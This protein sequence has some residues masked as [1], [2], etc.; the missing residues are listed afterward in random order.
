MNLVAEFPVSGKSRG[1]KY[2]IHSRNG[3]PIPGK[4]PGKIDTLVFRF[5]EKS[6]ENRHLGFPVSEKNRHLGFPV[7]GFSGMCMCRIFARQP[8]TKSPR[9]PPPPPASCSAG[10][11]TAPART[12][13]LSSVHPWPHNRTDGHNPLL[14]FSVLQAITVRMKSSSSP[15]TYEVTVSNVGSIHTG[16][17][18]VEAR[19][20]YG[21][22]KQMSLDNY[23][24]WAGESVTLW[25]DGEPY[26][27]FTG[28]LENG[29]YED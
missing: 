19:K 1:N 8:E 7:S 24:R 5:Q 12:G 25:R 6:G 9:K 13:T 18:P 17:N 2:G 16:T 10:G 27:V 3:F 14:R 11:P 26:L 21:E 28:S 15:H 22:A 20:H 29:T 23:G 4:I